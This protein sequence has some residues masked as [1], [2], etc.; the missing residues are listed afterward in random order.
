[1]VSYYDFSDHL[2]TNLLSLQSLL[3]C[4]KLNNPCCPSGQVTISLFPREDAGCDSRKNKTCPPEEE[5]KAIKCIPD[6]SITSNKYMC[7]R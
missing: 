1:M 5:K 4:S 6:N 3:F 7:K 2:K